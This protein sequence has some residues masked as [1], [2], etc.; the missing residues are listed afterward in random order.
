VLIS[1]I[2]VFSYGVFGG[3]DLIQNMRAVLN[4][5]D[6]CSETFV[7]Y[8]ML[9]TAQK[10]VV[11]IRDTGKMSVRDA[12]AQAME[13]A[14]WRETIASGQ[15]VLVKVNLS[16]VDP[17]MIFASNTD[18]EVVFAV[19]GI[20]RERTSDISLIESGGPR[21]TA[22]QVFRKNDYYNFARDLGVNLIDLS[23]EALSFGAHP[24]LEDFGVPKI[25]L[26]E[27]NALVTLPVLKTHAMT[28]FSGAL[29]NQWAACLGTIESCCIRISTSYC[30]RLTKC[31][32]LAFASWTEYGAWRAGAPQT[33]NQGN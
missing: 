18:R 32:V 6:T 14:G 9:E 20:L 31:F 13:A 21:V 26:D 24:L 7:I 27:S 33:G 23:K 16:S 12:V 4:L 2:V 10:T 25:L 17:R 22:E 28:F 29:K 8:P 15:R 30:P 11:S 3:N 19:C 1:F 5:P